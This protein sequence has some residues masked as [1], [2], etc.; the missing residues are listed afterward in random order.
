MTQQNPRIIFP[1]NP[2]MGQEFLAD[3][4][5]TYIWTGDRWS[6]TL[7]IQ[8]GTIV[9]ALDGEYADSPYRQN[10]DDT[11]DGGSA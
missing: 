4:I 11:F 10:V 7:A 9:P 8:A 1:K 6:A 3:N 5:I 2:T